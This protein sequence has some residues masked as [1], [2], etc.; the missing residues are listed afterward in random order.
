MRIFVSEFVCGG[1]WPETPAGSLA[2]EGRAMLLALVEDFASVPD[3]RVITTWDARLGS[4]PFE[5]AQ[6]ISVDD[7]EDEPAIFRELAAVCDATLIVAPETRYLLRDR[8]LL[9]ES[10][11]ARLLGPGS[12]GVQACTDK[13]ALF[14]SLEGAGIATIPTALLPGRNRESPGAAPVEHTLQ[15]P[16]VIKPI[17][18]AGSQSTYLIRDDAELLGLLPE[19]EADPL[20]AGAIWQPYIP[21]RAVS[22]ALLI[23]PDTAY[24]ACFPPAEQILS[25]DG[26]FQYLG[27]CVPARGVDLTAVE[28]AAKSAC[29][30]VAGLRG[31]VGVDLIVPDTAVV[32]R[33]PSG[34]ACGAVCRPLVVEINPRLTTS[35]V[36]YRK[37]AATNV[38]ERML[39]LDNRCSITWHDGH[40]AFNADGQCTTSIRSNLH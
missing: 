18:G 13:L 4:A 22:V 1:G 35:Y 37:L 8:C 2:S 31:Y 20:L 7:P 5:H 33:D 21:G 36:G 19:I 38:A 25:D 12:R 29:A 16:L 34:R 3:V 30:A 39:R 24:T 11:G 23:S 15:F 6:V 17:D 9:A 28:N 40:I 26:R 27:G 14:R 32:W 10:A